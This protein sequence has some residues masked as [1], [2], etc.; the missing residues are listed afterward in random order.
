M[1]KKKD[2]KMMKFFF[3]FIVSLNKKFKMLIKQFKKIL[4]KDTIRKG[5]IAEKQK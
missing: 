4:H 1:W 5:F 3:F 2:K